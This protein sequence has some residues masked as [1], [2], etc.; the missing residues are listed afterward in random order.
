MKVVIL[1]G[2]FGTRIRDVSE[3]IPKPMIPIGNRPIIWHIMKYYSM[4]GHNEF[5]LLLGYKSEV[6][7]NYF[8]NYSINSNDFKIT[9]GDSNSIK[10]LN[11][12][13]EKN[14]KITFAETGLNTMTG[15]RIKKIQ[16]YISEDETFMITYGDGLGNIDLKK[17]VDF[18]KSHGK[19]LTLTG[20]T[21]VGRFGEILTDGEGLITNFKEKPKTSSSKINGGFFI[22]NY[23]L[24]NFISN[25]PQE[26]FEKDPMTRLVE[27]KELMQF[28]H[29]GFW[30]PMDSQKEFKLLNEI[31]N[32]DK[33]E[34]KIW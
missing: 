23:S 27:S 18:H 5:I 19:A 32:N 17:L 15:G 16:K 9:L 30:Q 33:A 34:W 28:D 31:Y 7:K 13:E 22:A 4:F 3:N 11:E 14:W 8:V 10:F 26:I 29:D 21:P 2:G 25:D 1:C 24:F 12:C 6:I 20:V